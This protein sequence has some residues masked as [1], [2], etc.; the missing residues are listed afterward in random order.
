MKR[1][2]RYLSGYPKDS[3]LNKYLRIVIFFFYIQFA[4]KRS[5]SDDKGGFL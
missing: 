2:I 3:E 1:L 5:F 4:I